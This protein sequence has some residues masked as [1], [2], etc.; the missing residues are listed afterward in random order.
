L[1]SEK[2]IRLAVD[3]I[4]KNEP[5]EY[6]VR[7]GQ[8]IAVNSARKILRLFVECSDFDAYPALPS[9][10]APLHAMG[11]L[12]VFVVTR[13]DSRMS[14]MD[15]ELLKATA[16]TIRDK[17]ISGRVE[18]ELGFA[19]TKLE[20]LVTTATEYRDQNGPSRTRSPAPPRPTTIREHGTS[21][22]GARSQLRL[23]DGDITQHAD[24][25]DG[26]HGNLSEQMSSLDEDGGLGYAEWWPE[27]NS[28]MILDEFGWNWANFS[29]LLDGRGDEVQL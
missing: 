29:Q 22:D 3:V 25:R 26:L 17:Q 28:P 18:K 13:P 9:L 8:N 1:I 10:A 21:W 27:D 6:A 2:A 4:A 7:N 19:F 20:A 23:P 14:A 5:W 15:R 16:L 12:A 24:N 11:V